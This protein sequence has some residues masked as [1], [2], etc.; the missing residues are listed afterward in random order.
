MRSFTSLRPACSAS[1]TARAP[2]MSYSSSVRSF[3]GSSSTVSSQVRIQDPSGLWSLARSSFS[4]SLS[5][6]SR[7]FSGRSAASTRAR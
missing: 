7:T 3:Q 4:T 1:S 2:R 6:A 5:A